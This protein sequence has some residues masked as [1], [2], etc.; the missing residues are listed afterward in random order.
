L[1]GHDAKLRGN[2]L[3]RIDDGEESAIREFLND[4]PNLAYP[5]GYS[6]A[7]LRARRGRGRKKRR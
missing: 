7:S 2:Y 6:E 4:W 5:Y 1:T 3:D